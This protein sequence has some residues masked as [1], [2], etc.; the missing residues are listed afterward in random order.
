MLFQIR[1]SN[2]LA[3][4]VASFGSGPPSDPTTHSSLAGA[5]SRDESQPQR[6]FVRL[7]SSSSRLSSE[8]VGHT[9]NAQPLRGP[10]CDGPPRRDLASLRS[11][12]RRRRAEHVRTACC[13]ASPDVGKLPP[14]PS[15]IPVRST[16]GP[17][18]S[19]MINFASPGMSHARAYDSLA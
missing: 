11:P 4:R 7:C 14:K 15:R 12:A 16:N 19:K 17:S 13:M 5:S 2:S 1:C 6:C 8:I 10:A 9:P 3:K 18:Q